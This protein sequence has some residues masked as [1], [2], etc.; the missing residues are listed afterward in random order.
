M[1]TWDGDGQ[2]RRSVPTH[3]RTEPQGYGTNLTWHRKLTG[4]NQVGGHKG[5]S[6]LVVSRLSS[7]LCIWKVLSPNPLTATILTRMLCFQD[8]KSDQKWCSSRLCFSALHDTNFQGSPVIRVL[9]IHAGASQHAAESQ[10]TTGKAANSAC[11]SHYH[12]WCS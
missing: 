8:V 11:L 3:T 10:W 6:G 9:F 12:L 2:K 7:K 4:K 5:T 1:I